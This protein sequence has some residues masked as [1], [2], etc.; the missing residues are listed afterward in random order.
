M[1]KRMYVNFGH[2]SLNCLHIPSSSYCFNLCAKLKYIYCIMYTL[3]LDV[4]FL[5][6]LISFSSSWVLWWCSPRSEW[7]HR[8][9]WFPPWLSQLRQLYMADNNRGEEPNPANLRHFGAGGR[10]WYCIS[11]WWT[12]LTWQL[13]NEVSTHSFIFCL[14]WFPVPLFS[15]CLPSFQPNLP[16]SHSLNVH[17]LIYQ[18]CSYIYLVL[19]PLYILL[20]IFSSKYRR[21]LSSNLSVNF[22]T[23]K[24][25]RK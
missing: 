6:C 24:I 10:L 12:A 17:I 11:L 9:T 7:H 5:T 3:M 20:A 16:D 13:K 8:V 2:G 19:G 18:Q 14:M 1:Y 22:K 23:G 15:R 25:T 4:H 21:I